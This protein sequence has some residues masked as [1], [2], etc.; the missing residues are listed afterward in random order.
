VLFFRRMKVE[1]VPIVDLDNDPAALDPDDRGAAAVNADGLQRVLEW[2]YGEFFKA[3]VQDGTVQKVVE[4]YLMTRHRPWQRAKEQDEDMLRLDEAVFTCFHRLLMDAEGIRSMELQGDASHLWREVSDT[5]VLSPAGIL[6]IVA[7]FHYNHAEQTRAWVERCLILMPEMVSG[8]AGALRTAHQTVWPEIERK[9]HP[10]TTPEELSDMIEYAVDVSCSFSSFVYVSSSA[11]MSNIFR[12]A[13]VGEPVQWLQLYD[14]ITSLMMVII[15]K[16]GPEGFNKSVHIRAGL[17]ALVHA[18]VS[19]TLLGP[20]GLCREG[21]ES[22][23]VAPSSDLVENLLSMIETCAQGSMDGVCLADYNKAYDLVGRLKEVLELPCASEHSDRTQYAIQV[24]QS[25]PCSRWED[26]A[27]GQWT[28]LVNPKDAP[29]EKSANEKM[30]EKVVQVK[31]VLPELG[32]YFVEQLLHAV[33]GDPARAIQHMLEGSIPESVALL[34]Q[35][36]EKAQYVQ[37]GRKAEDDKANVLDEIGQD[38]PEMALIRERVRLAAAAYDQYDDEYD[39][40]YDD[41]GF[42]VGDDSAMTEMS[43]KIKNAVSAKARSYSNSSDEVDGAQ[44]GESPSIHETEAQ[45][46]WKPGMVDVDGKKRD[47]N[48]KIIKEE[49]LEGDDLLKPNTNANIAPPSNTKRKSGQKGRGGGS[50]G[51]APR[52]RGRG[53]GGGGRGGRG[54]KGTSKTTTGTGT[55]SNSGAGTKAEGGAKPSRDRKYKDANKA[56]LANH[57]RKRGAAKKQ[58]KGM[59]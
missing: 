34:D 2:E 14:T 3:F 36:L 19:A 42:D 54:G 43:A 41:A 37:I 16:L 56:R 29:R 6:D 58:A 18:S 53:R 17:L 57:S 49:D 35:S 44:N 27:T 39:D 4:S 59:F 46:K 50:T 55:A 1:I 31:E 52:G 48:G 15:A 11:T 32:T 23:E 40:A 47:V 8:V 22:W 13:G 20:L 21:E 25:I 24:I 45:K 38:D 33:R 30:R 10:S 9:L 7:L 26:G 28:G 12:M 5:G 51:G